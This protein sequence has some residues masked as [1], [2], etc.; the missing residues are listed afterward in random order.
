MIDPLNLASLK[1]ARHKAGLTQWQLADAADI[2]QSAISGI[3][4][5]RRDP[6][7]STWFKI[8]AVIREKM[9]GK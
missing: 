4:T 2:E 9:E 6:H 8:V 1:P 7:C 5:G 3:E